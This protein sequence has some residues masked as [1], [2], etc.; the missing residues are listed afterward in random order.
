[1]ASVCRDKREDISK[2]E[3]YIT[4]LRVEQTP[5]DH[6]VSSNCQCSA[7]ALLFVEPE[8]FIA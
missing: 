5:Q 8:H 2:M 4:A 1:M 7:S 6:I 3:K